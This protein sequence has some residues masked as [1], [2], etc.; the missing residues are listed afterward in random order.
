MTKQWFPEIAYE[1]IDDG[2]SANIPFINVPFE[3]L[4][5]LFL[6]IFESRETGEFEPGPE[7]EKLPIVEMDLH[8]YADMNFLKTKLDLETYDKVRIALGLE[9]LNDATQK[10]LAITQKIRENIE[11][12]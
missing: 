5:P 1:E 9:P 7:G 8:Q 4:M 3:E 10:G 6:F 2:I 11:E 12:K